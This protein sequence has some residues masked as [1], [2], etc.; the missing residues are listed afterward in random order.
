V[1][2]ETIATALGGAKKIDRSGRKWRCRCPCHEDSDPSLDLTDTEDGDVLWICRAGCD[3]REIGRILYRRGLLPP[4]VM[5]RLKTR[6]S[7]PDSYE[8]REEKPHVPVADKPAD[9][10]KPQW[11]FDKALPITGS[12]VEPYLIEV[13]GSLILPLHSAVRFM[14]AKPPHFPWPSMV[15]LVTDFADANR[16][17]TIHFTDLLP[18][19]SG[20]APVTPA[21]RTLKGYPTKGGVIRLTDDAEVTL[22]LGIAEGI[23]TALSVMSAFLRDEGRVEPVWTALNAGN[24]GDLPVVPGIETLVIYADHGPA[25]EKAANKLAERWLDADREVF[26]SVAPVDDWNPMVAS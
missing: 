7:T 2:A 24:M 5:E 11:L 3:K 26:I 9:S 21:K 23:E 8:R 25:G 10:G 22:R 18:D 14:P 1:T 20:K 4:K 12:P 15:S 13:R 16:A 19:G 17:L 6:K